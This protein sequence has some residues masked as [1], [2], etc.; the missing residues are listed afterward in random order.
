M[1]RL[2][3][4]KVMKRNCKR[5][6]YCDSLD[7]SVVRLIEMQ[8]EDIEKLDKDSQTECIIVINGDETEKEVDDHE[9]DKLRYAQSLHTSSRWFEKFI[10][11]KDDK[12]DH[13][14]F[15][16]IPTTATE[17]VKANQKAWL[18]ER[19]CAIL[20]GN[21][22]ELEK[23]LYNNEKSSC[24]TIHRKDK[25]LIRINKLLNS[26]CEQTDDLQQ[27]IDEMKVAKIRDDALYCT[28]FN[29]NTD[30][31][32][33]VEEY[34]NGLEKFTKFIISNNINKMWVGVFENIF[35]SIEGNKNG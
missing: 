24:E 29:S 16:P 33:E 34:Q 3:E 18:L 15:Y 2:E 20:S 25:E 11:G 17:I 30:L 26:R 31:E 6:K 22:I 1:N 4:L 23:E 35:E 14:L 19:K 21:I 7:E 32:K 5:V 10:L 12:K 27:T 8:I 9:V 28:L 13:F